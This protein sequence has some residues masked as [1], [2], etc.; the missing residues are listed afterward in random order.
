MVLMTPTSL[1][2]TGAELAAP[3]LQDK[4]AIFPVEQQGK[5]LIYLRYLYFD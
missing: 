4:L 5:I 3:K 1:P 2:I